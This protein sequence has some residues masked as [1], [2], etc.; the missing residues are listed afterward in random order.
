M[1]MCSGGLLTANVLLMRMI[2]AV[3]SRKPKESRFSYYWHTPD[4][5]LRIL[6]EYREMYPLGRL[7]VYCLAAFGTGIA[8]ALTVF[9]ILSL[10]GWLHPQ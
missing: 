10:Y 5:G 8:G 2:D 6:R 4:K 3:N 7:H 9:A 1:F